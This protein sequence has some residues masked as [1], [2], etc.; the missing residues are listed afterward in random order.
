MEWQQLAV[1]VSV[2]G[3]INALTMWA[4]QLM[5]KRHTKQTDDLFEAASTRDKDHDLKINVIEE[6][7]AELKL[8][9]ARD[10]VTRRD[11]V[12]AF[13]RCEQKIDAIWVF[14]HEASKNGSG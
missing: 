10:Y 13:G 7:L 1:I 12:I 11:F 14:L 5:M 3:A 9:V 6:K 2:I 8:E 4:V